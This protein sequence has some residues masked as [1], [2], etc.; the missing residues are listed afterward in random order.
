MAQIDKDWRKKEESFREIVKKYP[1]ISPFIIT[2]LD[3]Q[4]RGVAFTDAALDKVDPSIHQTRPLGD[5]LAPDS[6]L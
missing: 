4:R 5:R 6:L 3:V 2:Q 1:E